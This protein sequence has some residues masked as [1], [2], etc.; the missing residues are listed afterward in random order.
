MSAIL[1]IIKKV[2]TWV[3]VLLALLL[4]FLLLRG[5][6]TRAWAQLKQVAM[7]DGGDYSQGVQGTTP[8]ERDARNQELDAMAQEAYAQLTAGVVNPTA[9]E[10]A[11]AAIL[12]GT[13]D[14][15]LR[16]VAKSY[17]LLSRDKTLYQAV[18]SAWMSLSDVDERLMSRLANIAMI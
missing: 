17:K 6:L 7:R 8:E 14:T 13:N 4:A 3:W 2:P 12:E 18:D 10:R 1:A 11:L 5:P 16:V 15:E 9:R